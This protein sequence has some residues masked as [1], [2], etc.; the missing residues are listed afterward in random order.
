MRNASAKPRVIAS[1]VRSPLRSSSALVATVV[2][3]RTT[4]ISPGG[5]GRSPR[6]EQLANALDGRI[7]VAL[8]VLRQQLQRDERA[9]GLAADDVRERAA[10]IDPELPAAG[11]CEGVGLQPDLPGQPARDR[12][13]LRHRAQHD[14]RRP[15]A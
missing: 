5:I 13:G 9:V 15:A 8:R 10:A 14:S 6:S 12:L 11:S 2:P 7:A 4:S 1:T 3:I